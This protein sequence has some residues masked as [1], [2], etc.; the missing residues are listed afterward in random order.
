[1]ADDKSRLNGAVLIVSNT[2]WYIYNFRRGLIKE[3]QQ[4]GYAVVDIAPPDE[5]AERLAAIGARFLPLPMDN[6]GT[7]PLKDLRLA[8]ALRRLL[9]QERPRCAL[10]FTVKPNVFGAFAA[11]SLGIPVITNISGLGT[12]FIKR[13]WVTLVVRTLYRSALGFAS[14]VFFQN[15]ED[16]ELF[17]SS[18]LVD[19]SKAQ[20]LPGSGVDVQWFAPVT[21]SDHPLGKFRFLLLGRLLWDKGVGE[22]VD[23]ATRVRQK[24]PDCEFVLMGFT[25]IDNVTAI[26]T[27]KIEDWQRSGLL[28]YVAPAADVRDELAKAHC[29]VLPSYREGTPK[30]LLE[31]SSMAIPIIATDVPG[32]RQVVDDGATGFLVKV[33]DAADLAEKMERMVRLPE[34]ERRAMGLRGREKMVRE[35]DERIVIRAYLSAVDRFASRRAQVP[36]G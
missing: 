34:S 35:F 28:T 23:A 31:A 30:A 3:L 8:F 26:P 20:L 21:P 33:R 9:R 1:M 14:K 36:I 2:A 6:K 10:T 25:D 19:S 22:Y 24:F 12:V 4:Q 16:L 18:R 13:N 32:C 11:R 15:P 27:S 5:Y 29:V 7:N 17:V